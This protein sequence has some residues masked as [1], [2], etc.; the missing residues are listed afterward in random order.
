[1]TSITGKSATRSLTSSFESEP[2]DE[3]QVFTVSF[4]N[5]KIWL[6]LCPAQADD[7]EIRVNTKGSRSDDGMGTVID[8]LAQKCVID[9]MV[10]VT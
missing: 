9:V 6:F 10:F 3:Y 4:K 5:G 8:V 1:M 7:G 2:S